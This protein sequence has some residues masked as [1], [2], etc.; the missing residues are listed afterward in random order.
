MIYKRAYV[1][2]AEERRDH[3]MNTNWM[4]IAKLTADYFTCTLT[5]LFHHFKKT[6]S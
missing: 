4:D 2:K 6:I 3:G 1:G 5:S